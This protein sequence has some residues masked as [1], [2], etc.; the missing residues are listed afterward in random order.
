[1]LLFENILMFF[2][3]KITALRSKYCILEISLTP[4][5]K[6]VKVCLDFQKYLL[7]VRVT[8]KTTVLC[9]TVKFH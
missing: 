3:L 1:M 7:M 2:F 6:A 4:L 9:Y 5:S 8:V